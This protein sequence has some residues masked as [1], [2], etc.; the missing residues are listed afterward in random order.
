MKILL[1][2]QEKQEKY[3]KSVESKSERVYR[4]QKV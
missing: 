4:P 1:A 3:F 2:E